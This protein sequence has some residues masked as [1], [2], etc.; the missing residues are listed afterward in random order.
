MNTHQLLVS[1]LVLAGLLFRGFI[2][3]LPAAGL[4]HVGF[5]R[6]P[7]WTHLIRTPLKVCKLQQQVFSTRAGKK[8]P[9]YVFS[10]SIPFQ[11]E[12]N[13][14]NNLKFSSRTGS[15]SRGG[16]LRKRCGGVGPCIRPAVSSAP[17]LGVSRRLSEIPTTIDYS[18]AASQGLSYTNIFAI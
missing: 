16:C 8:H 18:I 4:V 12:K 10:N 14:D 3:V 15:S 11:R 6:A 1:T 13:N 5:Y 7:L 2:G 9:G 17:S